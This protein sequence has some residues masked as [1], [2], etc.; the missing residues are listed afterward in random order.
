[1][2]DQRPGTPVR[3]SRV[4]PAPSGLT[5]RERP[6]SNL[7]VLPRLWLLREGRITMSRG[8][9]T[10]T[11]S[12][13]YT[14]MRQQ[15]DSESIVHHLWKGPPALPGGPSCVT[16]GST[17]EPD[18]EDQDHQRQQDDSYFHVHHPPSSP[19]GVEDPTGGE[20]RRENPGDASIIWTGCD[21]Q[22][23]PYSVTPA[24][25]GLGRCDLVRPTRAM[26][27]R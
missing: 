16:W 12:P 6:R 3:A 1:M 14:G 20:V 27:D 18:H 15:G 11:P 5:S 4:R 9:V 25:V 17:L 2:V 7:G 8:T 10:L 13:R 26:L 24:S 21:N 22:A 19:V 23:D